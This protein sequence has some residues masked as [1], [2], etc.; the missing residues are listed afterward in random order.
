MLNIYVR[1]CVLFSGFFSRRRRERRTFGL[2][3]VLHLLADKREIP[4]P[5]GWRETGCVASRDGV[6]VRVRW[7]KINS[8]NFEFERKMMLYILYVCMC[9]G[10]LLEALLNTRQIKAQKYCF[11]F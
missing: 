11:F 1:V 9:V 10:L 4:A 3:I 2:V 5:D 7:R 8:H 6:V